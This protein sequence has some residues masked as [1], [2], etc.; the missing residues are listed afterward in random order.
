MAG[1][2]GGEPTV[3]P[4]LHGTISVISLELCGVVSVEAVLL[5]TIEAVQPPIFDNPNADL[6]ILH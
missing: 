1:L 4:M 2:I 5:G 3:T 6:D